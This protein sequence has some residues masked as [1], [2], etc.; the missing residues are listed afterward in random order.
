MPGFPAGAPGQNPYM[1]PMNFPQMP[2]PPM[3]PATGDQKVDPSQFNQQALEH[4]QMLAYMAY[5]QQQYQQYQAMVY[6]KM[7]QQV[8][9]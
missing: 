3:P 6:Q 2:M 8:M 9:N 5:H 1:M 7:M 4:Q